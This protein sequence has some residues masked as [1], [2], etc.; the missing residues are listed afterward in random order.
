VRRGNPQENQKTTSARVVAAARRVR[1]GRGGL[2][3]IC[4]RRYRHPSCSSFYFCSNFR[5]EARR[6]WRWCRP[7]AET[8]FH[9]EGGR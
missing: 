6:W 3:L 2:S 8:H 5:S 4:G 1:L 7:L 9:Q